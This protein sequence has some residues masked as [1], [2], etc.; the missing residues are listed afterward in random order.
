MLNISKGF[1]LLE[2]MV[3]VV[4]LG[5]LAGAIVPKLINKP[6]EVRK[7]RAQSD[8]RTIEA[9]LNLYKLDNFIYPTTEQGLEALVIK[10]SV[11]P[12]PKHWKKEGYL[13]TVPIDPW[14]NEYLYLQPGVKTT[15]DI[16]SLGLDGE[17]N[18]DE[19]SDD[20]GNW[21]LK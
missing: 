10:P 15:M 17:Q 12:L 16:Y 3:V 1:T 21:D 5:I 9:A 6:E 4:I 19:E 7:V 14:G 18:D 11:D 13:G 20:I 8:I 2:I